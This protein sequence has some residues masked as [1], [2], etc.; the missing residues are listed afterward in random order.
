MKARRN[1]HI[2]VA[3]LHRMAAA[4]H[5]SIPRCFL[6]TGYA[7]PA[8]HYVFEVTRQCNL[9]CQMCFC[10]KAPRLMPAGD[11]A[12]EELTTEQWL[13][14][15]DQTSR[16]SLITFTGGEPLGRTDFLSLLEY[17][18]ARQRTHFI[19]NGTQLGREEAQRAVASAPNRFGGKGLTF[20]GISLHGPRDVHDRIVGQA[21]AF[22]KAVSGIENLVRCREDSGKRYPLIHVTAV[23]NRDNVSVLPE[24]PVL[25]AEAGADIVNL[26][27]EV[28]TPDLNELETKEPAH[29]RSVELDLPWIERNELDRA[30]HAAKASAQSA[31][32]ELRLP[33]MPHENLLSYYD[34]GLDLSRF[35]CGSAW[36]SLV[37]SASGGVYPCFLHR[38]GDIHDKGLKVTWNGS[39][40]RTFRKT[41][42][43]GL[44]P[45]CQG[46]CHTHWVGESNK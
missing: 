38:V 23:I 5:S 27:R 25:A 12:A 6:K 29:Y 10:Q 37:V 4:I 43:T 1:R 8:L 36:T 2:S 20:V 42:Q 39:R 34:G 7:F 15:I 35:A 24:I 46:C 26:A 31:E 3:R 44:F 14:L 33:D 32:I 13:N 30:I 11:L 9:Q 28:C 21:G 22:D 45:I 18:S 17:A 16:L 41:L 19:T 40:M